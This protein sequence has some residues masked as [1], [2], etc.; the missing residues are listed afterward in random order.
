V[1]NV[2]GPAGSFNGGTYGPDVSFLVDE[3]LT[4][5]N[6]NRWRPFLCHE[7]FH[8]WNGHAL[9]YEGQEYWISEGF[10]DYYAQLL[11]LRLGSQSSGDFTADMERRMS[12]YLLAHRA[13]VGL[14]AAGQAK[15]E[16]RALVY[17]GGSLAALCLDLQIRAA[18]SNKKSLDDVMRSLYAEF[19]VD[20]PRK[21]AITDV[22]RVTSNIAGRTLGD[23]FA[24]HVAGAEA[25]PLSD[26]LKLAGIDMAVLVRDLPETKWI[27][28]NLLHCP[29]MT[30][31]PG[32]GIKI[33][34]SKSDLLRAGD[35]LFEVEGTPT[36]SFDDLRLAFGDLAPRASFGLTVMR[37][38]KRTP[39]RVAPCQD[40]SSAPSRS[41][42]A[43]VSL[44][45]MATF[46]PVTL[47]IRQ[48]IFGAP[49]G[50]AG[51]Q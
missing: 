23:F 44:V 3:P 6:A 51:T 2:G 33:I 32:I 27:A 25:L 46:D 38:G 18:S 48:S 24:R 14:H 15:F 19:G 47:A 29:S 43:S 45:M 16:N 40:L 22:I 34:R 20:P 31:I 21:V 1:G 42:W 39:L 11:L 37:D 12:R 35:L 17:D 30:A 50:S 49:L 4:S 28:A 41:P 10:T 13:D 5:A 9:D 26:S 8:L 36:K 7:L